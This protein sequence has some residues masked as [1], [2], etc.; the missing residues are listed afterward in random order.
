MPFYLVLV[1]FKWAFPFLRK[2]SIN[3]N[4]N[5]NKISES[6]FQSLTVEPNILPYHVS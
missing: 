5:N 6:Y 4:N 2:D 1:L 3:N